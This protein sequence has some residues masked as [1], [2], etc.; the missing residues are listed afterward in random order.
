MRLMMRSPIVAVLLGVFGCAAPPKLKVPPPND[1]H[2]L[3]LWTAG[4]DSSESDYLAVY[5]VRPDSTRYGA[6]VTTVPVGSGGNWPHHSEHQLAADRQLFVNGFGTGQSWIFDLH[7]PGQP[8]IVAQFGD[9]AGF[10]H[11]HSFVRLPNGNVLATF[12]MRHDSTGM[13]PGGLVELTPTGQFVR[14]SP[15][16]L[17]GVAE[18]IRPYSAAVIPSLDRI[19]STTT[20]MDPAS[21]YPASEIQVWKLS[22]LELLHTVALPP[23]P[24]GDENQLT[25]EPRLLEDGKTV[26]VSTFNCG[27]FLLDGLDGEHPSGQLVASFPRK[28]DTNCAIP[29]A[30]GH[31]WVVTV[32]SI[33]AVVALDISNPA[34]PREV[35]RVTLDSA[36]VPHWI[37]MEPNSRRIVITGYGALKH[38]VLVATFDSLTGALALDERFRPAGATRPGFELP[39]IPHGAVFSLP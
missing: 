24:L 30:R 26:M 5:D 15:A 22:T 17:P 18:G 38:R 32:P 3:Y 20:D 6:L 39:G 11:P 14:M 35:S 36:D 13:H 16:G 12:Q 8:R 29:I 28:P 34:A 1:S 7:D 10:R 23:G 2:Y 21:T 37:G 33:P 25:A 31:H 4:A 9:Q 27:L 19:V